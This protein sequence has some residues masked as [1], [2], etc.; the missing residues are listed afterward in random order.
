MTEQRGDL[1][2]SCRLLRRR[3]K[4]SSARGQASPRFS[5]VSWPG[6]TT[7]QQARWRFE[8]IQGSLEMKLSWK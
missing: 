1:C 4:V 6:T 7:H 2:K 3:E 5:S 8:M